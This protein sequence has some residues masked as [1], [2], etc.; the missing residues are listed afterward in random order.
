MVLPTCAP[1]DQVYII[2]VD[3][4]RTTKTSSDALQTRKAVPVGKANMLEIS[5]T[6][7]FF[8]PIAFNVI[9]AVVC[10]VIVGVANFLVF[11]LLLLN[12]SLFTA[13]I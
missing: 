7:K 8:A 6:I 5:T 4:I 1:S 10:S 2:H 3:V 11:V 9:D 13:G 12:F